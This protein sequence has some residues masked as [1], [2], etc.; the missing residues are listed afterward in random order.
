MEDTTTPSDI[1]GSSFASDIIERE[2]QKIRVVR[3]NTSQY[4]RAVIITDQTVDTLWNELIPLV[5]DFMPDS[6]AYIRVDGARN[7]IPTI[8]TRIT[9]QRSLLNKMVIKIVG[10]LQLRVNGTC[11]AQT[12][13]YYSE[14]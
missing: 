12:R 8:G 14:N 5:V 9:H 6:G 3:E 1:I 2:T 10:Q 4:T 13:Q 11:R 7:S